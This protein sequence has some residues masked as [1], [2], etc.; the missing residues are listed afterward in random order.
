MKQST[1]NTDSKGSVLSPTLL[2]T[3]TSLVLILD[4]QEH[5]MKDIKSTGLGL[6]IEFYRDMQ[7]Q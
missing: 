4:Y 1:T 7:M 5:V 6:I 2:T 3:E